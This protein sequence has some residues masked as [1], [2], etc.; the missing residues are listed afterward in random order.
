MRI[1]LVEDE[2][3]AAQVLAKGLREQ[4]YAVDVAR[5]GD[6]ALY[7]ASITDYDAIV[8]DVMLPGIDGFTVCR[9][10]RAQGS[11]VPVLMLTARDAVDARITGL[12]SGA[13]DYLVK[14]F[15]F[16][17]LLARLRAV[18]RRGQAPQRPSDVTLGD[19]RIDL[20]ARHVTRGRDRLALTTREFAL[21]EFLVLHEGEVVG[22]GEIAEHVWDTAFESMSNVIDVMIQRLRRKIDPPTGPSFIVTRRGEGYMLVRPDGGGGG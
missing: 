7:Q 4:S 2:P 14:P 10:L 16:G 18:I 9:E 17:E 15:D 5:D 3:R 6:D 13:D 1:L 21:L 12:D 20:R 22:R 8:L 11:H 19:L